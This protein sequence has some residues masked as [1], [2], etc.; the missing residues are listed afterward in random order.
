MFMGNTFH[1]YAASLFCGLLVVLAGCSDGRDNSAPVIDSEPASSPTT[2]PQKS[3][4]GVS[5]AKTEKGW[6]L[7]RNG[8]PYF[9]KGAGGDGSCELLAKLGGNSIRT[10][11]T[12]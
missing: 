11:G 4:A 7:L 9:V 10:W 12:E 8:S 6:E 2:A 3:V 5:L 1:V